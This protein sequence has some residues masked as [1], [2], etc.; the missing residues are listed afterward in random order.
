[1]NRGGRFRIEKP[2]LPTSVLNDVQEGFPVPASFIYKDALLS[3]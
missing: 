3:A 1:M 2:D